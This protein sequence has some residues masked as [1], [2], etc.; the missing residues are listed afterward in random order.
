MA[1]GPVGVGLIGAGNISDQYLTQLTTF[2]DVRVLAVADVIEER[3]KAQ[4]A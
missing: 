4:A 1:G 3:A 2:P